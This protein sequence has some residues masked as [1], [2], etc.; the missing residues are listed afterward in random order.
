MRNHN[1]RQRQSNNPRTLS[2]NDRKSTGEIVD[3]ARNRWPLG[4][5]TVIHRI[6]ELWPER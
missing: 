6:G 3:E 2:G 4:R 5:V 1:G